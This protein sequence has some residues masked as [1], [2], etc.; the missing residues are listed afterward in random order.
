MDFL[1]AGLLLLADC[2][3]KPLNDRAVTQG[4]STT[5][6]CTLPPS[7]GKVMEPVARR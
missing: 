3:E 5:S 1:G 2:R 4:R 7:Q 6:S